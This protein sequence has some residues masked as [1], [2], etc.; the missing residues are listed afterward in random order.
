MSEVRTI[1]WVISILNSEGF[2]LIPKISNQPKKI[3]V[4]PEI[5]NK[6]IYIN[7]RD[8]LKAMLDELKSISTSRQEVSD[9][10][11]KWM[12]AFIFHCLNY[13][14]SPM[15]RFRPDREKIYEICYEF[16]AVILQATIAE[17]VSTTH[18]YDNLEFRGDTYFKTPTIEYLQDEL[19]I[20]NKA[21]ITVLKH[22]FENTK[23]MA[24]LCDLL[25][26]TPLIRSDTIEAAIKEDVFESMMGAL[27]YISKQI[28]RQYTE[29]TE[30]VERP[31]V[32]KRRKEFREQAQTEFK[33][34]AGL[35]RG[36]VINRFVRMLFNNCDVVIEAKKPSKTTLDAIFVIFS[37]KKNKIMQR[38][39]KNKDGKEFLELS[40]VMKP[41][42]ALDFA[43]KSGI[44]DGMQA[45]KI[46]NTRYITS[47]PAPVKHFTEYCCDRMMERLKA[48]G[49]KINTL[50]HFR[51]IK[52]LGI[53]SN[54]D[55]DRAFYDLEVKALQA[56]YI[57]EVS[58]MVDSFGSSMISFIFRTEDYLSQNQ[59]Y[60][61]QAGTKDIIDGAHAFLQRI[62]V[63][64]SHNSEKIGEYKST[65]SLRSPEASTWMKGRPATFDPSVDK[66]KDSGEIHIA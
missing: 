47:V 29:W 49:M 41:E 17:N 34:L 24:D 3:F 2:T 31:D 62:P 23:S 4:S 48:A 55:A 58:S 27:D 13:G 63:L 46:L 14:L 10:D 54:T 6:N 39:L 64:K 50:Q 65:T 35:Y 33:G 7:P 44:D 9:R 22:H 51:S 61:V 20:R 21:E 66:V 45:V 38:S 42:Y 56:G 8:D 12:S 43:A 60:M 15:A 40:F 26:I 16:Q 19:G 11:I 57:L 28:G 18:N 30:R 36:T 37:N 5:L 52:V 25:W 1:G 32:E 59:K 53:S